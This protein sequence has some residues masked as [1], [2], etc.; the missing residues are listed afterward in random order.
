MSL[1]GHE[2]VTA[3]FPL[4]RPKNTEV[5]EVL[6]MLREEFEQLGHLVV[7]HTAVTPEQT[8]AIRKLHEAL[9]ATIAAVVL[10][11]GRFPGDA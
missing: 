10:H 6:D 4:H 7:G 9:Q 5:A 8:I 11:Q 2:L 1:T 3:I